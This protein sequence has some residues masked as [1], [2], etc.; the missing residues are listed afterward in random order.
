M[1]ES[2]DIG[3]EGLITAADPDLELKGRRG[4]LAL[5]AFLPSVIFVL[6]RLSITRANW[7]ICC[8][9]ADNHHGHA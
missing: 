7:K 1:N 9:P 2:G 5:L 6:I 8:L 4:L 3:R